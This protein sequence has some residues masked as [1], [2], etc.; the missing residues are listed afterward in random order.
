MIKKKVFIS[1]GI[2]F[3]CFGNFIF[4]QSDYTKI[5]TS[6]EELKTSSHVSGTFSVPNP[7]LAASTED[8][9]V[10][11]GDIYELGFSAN[12]KAVAY[13]IVVDSSYSVKVANVG[14]VNGYG[15]TFMQLKK[16]VEQIINKNYPMSGVQLVIKSPASFKV[17]LAGEVNE[18]SI[19]SAW[20]LARLSAVINDSLTQ[21]SS[22][23]NIEIKSHDG[24]VKTYDLFKAKRDAD[25]SQD[26]Y[27]RPD[28][29]I[30]I[31]R[32]DRTVSIQGAVERPG[33]YELLQGEN[34]KELI[35]IYGG[36][37]LDR[38][39]LS[40]IEILRTDGMVKSAGK[41]IYLDE[42]NIESNFE[43][44]NY[45][46]VYIYSY[47]DLKPIA[48]F[49]GAVLVSIGEDS[50]AELVGSNKISI[51]FDADE[52]YAFFI[53]RNA[54]L[55]TSIS[56]L[57]NAYIRRGDTFIPLNLEEILYDSDYYSTEVVKNYDTIL[58]PFLQSF[59]TVAG[60][61]KK[62]GR[63]PYIP[64]RNWSYYIGLAG[65]FDKTE[66]AGQ[67]VTIKDKNNKRHSKGDPI[68][69]ETTITAESTAFTYYFNKYAPLITTTLT[70]ISTVLT[71]YIATKNTD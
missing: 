36:G 21:F 15:K 57:K 70:A 40:R 46:T 44:M 25:M 69:P 26:P 64:D 38:A 10:T 60:A 43:V 24:T 17:T 56:D 47:S 12:G 3:L 42:K 52:N 65:G 1:A 34:I 2:I 27:L 29:V 59:V 54:G 30:T 6:S 61:V 33:S 19:V 67:V 22:M 50:A 68:T 62:P 71:I 66:N 49:E 45:D 18:T 20:G 53:R 9:L 8:Y 37:L 23:R 4:S 14:V 58:I 13:S 35:D 32:K 5:K 55:F 48:F 51:T 31:G 41:K 7:Q 11:A 63:Y 16:E 39:D 28:D